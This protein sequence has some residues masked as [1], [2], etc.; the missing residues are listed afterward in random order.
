MS[1]I[2]P[3]HARLVDK[4]GQLVLLFMFFSLCVGCASTTTFSTHAKVPVPS[5]PSPV[6][7][8]ETNKVSKHNLVMKIDSAPKI[9]EDPQIATEEA[10]KNATR[11]ANSKQFFNSSIVFNYEPNALY[12]IYVSPLRVTS[13]TL[14]MNEK[15]V[16]IVGGDDVRWVISETTSGAKD[17]QFTHF[18]IKPKQANIS[19]NLFVTTDRRAYNLLVQALD[20]GNFMANVR[21]NYPSGQAMIQHTSEEWDNL[22]S[23]ANKQQFLNFNYHLVTRKKPSW[24][25]LRVFDDGAKTFIEF[26][27]TIEFKQ[28]PA[29]FALDNT[30]QAST[31][32]Y[33]QKD[34]VYILDYLV[35]IGEIKLL[36]ESVGF[37]KL[38]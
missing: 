35:E 4:S 21:W 17:A 28:S 26:P 24:M 12:E 14:E 15:L 25:P 27:R 29:L 22:Q 16:S 20:D 38:Q 10:N 23:K 3:L 36:N 32:N 37:E 5:N 11:K 18:L 31:V 2:F 7:S 30:G 8:E 33:R 19:T 9:A 1:I 6:A 34:N 13:V